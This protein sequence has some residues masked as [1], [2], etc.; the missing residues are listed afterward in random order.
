MPKITLANDGS[1]YE[2]NP[3]D[4]PYGRHGKPLSILDLSMHFDIP[5]NHDCGGNCACTTC[6]II[7][8]KGAE[9]CSE[10][11]LTEQD[12][13]GMADGLTPD[14]RLGCQCVISGDVEFEIPS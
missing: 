7:I 9:N 6:H 1:T 11:D 14:S 13:L 3:A 2:F 12:T 10:I 4:V 8:R 5:L